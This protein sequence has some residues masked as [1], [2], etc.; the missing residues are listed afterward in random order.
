MPTRRVFR[1]VHAFLFLRHSFVDRALG[2]L[3]AGRVA[4][5]FA[6]FRVAFHAIDGPLTLGVDAQNHDEM[7]FLDIPSL[8]P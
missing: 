2:G 7:L 3:D 5:C 4:R 8:A 1:T 6:G